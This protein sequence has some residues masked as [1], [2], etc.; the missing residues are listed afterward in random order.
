MARGAL[1]GGQKSEVK[2]ARVSTDTRGPE[3]QHWEKSKGWGV[4]EN[5]IQMP[6]LPLNKWPWAS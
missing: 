5:W 3:G 6:A 2:T 1:I 4:R